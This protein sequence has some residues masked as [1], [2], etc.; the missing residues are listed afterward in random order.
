MFA[1][2][3]FTNPNLLTIDPSTGVVS[4]TVPISNEEAL[5][6]LA[7]DGRR[8]WS[9]DGYNDGAS[10][11]TFV[12]KPST[13]V[14]TVV[15]D[16]GFN[17]N[18]RS[19]AI[20]PHTG[21]LYGMTDNELYTINKST[22]AAASIATISGPTLDQ[23]TALAIDSGGTAYATDITNTGLFTV[24]LTSGQ[25]GHLGDL[26]LGTH[27]NDLAFDHYDQLWGTAAGDGHLYIIDTSTI[28]A[29]VAFPSRYYRAITFGVPRPFEICLPL[30]L[31]NY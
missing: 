14:G 11:R 1:L 19:V 21:V 31:R 13:G 25:A 30:V 6:G 10:D 12:I 16:T 24:S 28:S 29:T 15:G 23:A 18:F 22:G 5:N 7:Y 4:Q 8:L 3:S 2:S 9:I 20:H 17:W 26:S 27:F